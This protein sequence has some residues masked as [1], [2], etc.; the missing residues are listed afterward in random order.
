M[1]DEAMKQLPKLLN[2]EFDKAQQAI[3]GFKL[4]N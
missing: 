1:L 4:P 2:G 3:N